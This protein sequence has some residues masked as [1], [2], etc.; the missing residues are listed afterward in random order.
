MIQNLAHLLGLKPNLVNFE[1]RW[2]GYAYWSH[3][4]S[5]PKKD[6][7]KKIYIYS[8]SYVSEHATHSDDL[9]PIFRES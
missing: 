5:D 8:L 6:F 2:D 1:K 3:Q 9:Y 4:D 7:I